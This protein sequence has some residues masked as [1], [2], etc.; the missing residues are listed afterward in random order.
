MQPRSAFQMLSALDG[1]DAAHL[2]LFP[3]SSASSFATHQQLLP[4]GG[5]VAGQLYL[6]CAYWLSQPDISLE[7]QA[8]GSASQSQKVAPDA[9]LHP[10]P[11]S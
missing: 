6:F 2:K 3:A 7:P 1:L 10:L 11:L 8:L 5:A 9:L 4:P